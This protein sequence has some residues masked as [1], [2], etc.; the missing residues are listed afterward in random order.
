MQKKLKSIYS[1][2]N[3]FLSLYHQLATEEEHA[4]E[5]SALEQLAKVRI[6][7][8]GILIKNGAYQ[9]ALAKNMQAES[10]LKTKNN[11]SLLA[12]CWRKMAIIY[13]C[14]GNLDK[15]IYYNLLTL[16]SLRQAKDQHEVSKVLNNLGHCYIENEQYDKAL[17]LFLTNLNDSTLSDDLYGATMKNLGQLHL[18]T[19]QL[20]KA[21]MFFVKTIA[22]AQEKGLDI[23]MAGSFSY[24]GKI[25]IRKKEFNIALEYMNKTLGLLKNIN[26]KREIELDFYTDLLTILIELKHYD[27][28]KIIFGRYQQLNKEITDK[29]ISQSNKSTQFLYGIHKKEKEQALLK[30]RNAQLKNNNQELKQFAHIVSHDLKQ[31]IRTVNSF[32]G[33]L[34][35]EL[36]NNLSER[37]VEFFDIINSSCKEMIS[38]VDSVLHFAESNATKP[39]KMVD[40]NEILRKVV[41][42]VKALLEETGG[43]VEFENLP[44]ILG[45]PT[46]I[47]Q[48]FQNLV[49]NGL[50]FRRPAVK[51]V[52]KITAI[53]HKRNWI[54]SITD[55]GIGIANKDKDRIFNM[56]ERIDSSRQKG[57]GIGLSTVLSII[58]RYSGSIN[59]DS[60]QGEGSTFTL[61]LPNYK[62]MV[63]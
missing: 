37:S 44:S 62:L 57:S 21:E 41:K 12:K 8:V 23:Y 38:F 3:S 52:V 48:I 14:L 6:E 19:D 55:N 24:L 13:G 16:E 40:C 60:V 2:Q 4:I 28:V 33:L 26:V 34:K 15:R 58:K 30:E 32:A 17:P 20:E 1:K 59:I 7:L 43:I 22:F 27:Q 54:F 31:P 18:E 11:T 9:E 5:T 50:K 51:P 49:T 35:R 36:G 63:N 45:Y 25:A 39:F 10:Y 56:F 47:L 42:N 53:Q 29:V 46:E 61:T